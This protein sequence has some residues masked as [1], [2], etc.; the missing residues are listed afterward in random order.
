[1]TC[2]RKPMPN[3]GYVIACTRGGRK[4]AKCRW[5][6]QHAKLL[7]DQSVTIESEDVEMKATC[8]APFCERHGVGIGNRKHLCKVC[9]IKADKWRE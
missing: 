8:D 9:A 6:E 5:C 3:G 2:E 4:P 1:M 7:C